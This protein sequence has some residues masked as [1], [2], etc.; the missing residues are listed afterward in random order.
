ML[1]RMMSMTCLA[2]MGL[3]PLSQAIS[4]AVIKRNLTGLFVIAGSLPTRSENIEREVDSQP[5]T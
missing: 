2:G 3:V 1:G 5:A 4:G